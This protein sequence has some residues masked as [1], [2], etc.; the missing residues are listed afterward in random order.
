MRGN[1]I[2]VELVYGKMNR[3]GHMYQFDY[4]QILKFTG[5][6]L[7][8]AYEVHFSNEEH[9]DS[10]TSIGDSNGVVI[11]DQFFLS[12]EDIYFWIYLHDDENDGE[13]EYSGVIPIVERTKP[14]NYEPTP[15]Q[16]DTITQAI[17]ALDAAVEQTGLDV[18]ATNDAKEAAQE[19]QRLA[20]EAQGKAE[21]AQGYAEDAQEAAETAKE[22]AEEAQRK[23]ETA[24]GFAEAAKDEA[25]RQAGIAKDEADRAEDEADRAEQAAAQAGYMFFEIVDG[26]LIYH[27]TPNVQVRFYLDDGDM[28]VEEAV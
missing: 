20:E 23:A 14:T 21:D 12:G 19:A 27:R 18:I 13:T 2:S 10:I 22:A 6:E 5:V 16:Q 11:P 9:G 26:D 15:V 28:Y 24:Q 17:A 7:P 4:G 8:F 3:T 1:T 25:T